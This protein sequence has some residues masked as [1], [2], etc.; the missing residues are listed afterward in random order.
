MR[1]TGKEKVMS[2]KFTC[3]RR[4][5][6]GH[7]STG[8]PLVMDGPNLDE[9]RNDKTC[10]YDGSLR[11][12]AFMDYVRSGKLVGSTDK[13]YKFYLDEYEGEVRGAKK[14]YTHHLSDEQSNEFMELWLAGK[15]NWGS[16]PPYVPIY[17]PGLLRKEE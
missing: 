10:S 7:A 4:Q 9:W 2:E 5:A 15:I 8:S 3:P 12:D 14:F 6:E 13:S 16:F 17:L 1:R 11:P